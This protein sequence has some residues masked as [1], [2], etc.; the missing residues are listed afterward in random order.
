MLE[1]ALKPNDPWTVFA[2]AERVDNDELVQDGPLLGHVFT[3]SKVSV[4]VI[5]D[6]RVAEHLKVG[7]GGLYA[8]NFVP[9]ALASLYGQTDPHGAMAFIRLKVD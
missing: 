1:S 9:A 6:W 4:G 7:V 8:L 3:V 2:R 5:H